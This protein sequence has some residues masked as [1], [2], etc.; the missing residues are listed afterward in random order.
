MQSYIAEGESVLLVSVAFIRPVL[1]A[2]FLGWE[3]L[4]DRGLPHSALWDLA[5]CILMLSG[6]LQVKGWSTD[7]VLSILE[8]LIGIL[9]QDFME[10][11]LLLI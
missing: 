9:H 4:V 8:E 11:M 3:D 6:T 2:G 5:K 10:N 1:P 7:S